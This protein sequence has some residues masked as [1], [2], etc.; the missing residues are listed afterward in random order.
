M[1]ACVR[2][3]AC[4]RAWISLQDIT[5]RRHERLSSQ[6]NGSAELVPLVRRCD[7]GVHHQA[8]TTAQ[9]C[10]YLL[11]RSDLVFENQA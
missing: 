3:C 2:A 5:R 11:L 10:L 7:V 4:A 9:D 6:D 8:L 1:R